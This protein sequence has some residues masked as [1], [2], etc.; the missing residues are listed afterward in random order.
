MIRRF[1]STSSEGS[2]VSFSFSRFC[3]KRK[4]KTKNEKRESAPKWF[5]SPYERALTLPFVN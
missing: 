3:R 4:Q 2:Y 1:L 5:S